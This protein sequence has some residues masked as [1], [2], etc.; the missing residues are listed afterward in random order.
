[1][2][3][4]LTFSRF[5]SPTEHQH[6][7]VTGAVSCCRELGL[8]IGVFN[9]EMMLTPRGPRLIEVNARMGGFYLHNW[10]R[11]IYGVDLVHLALMC[12]CGVRPV[13]TGGSSL[14]EEVEDV[15][16][17]RLMGIMLYPSR[18]R[19]ALQTTATPERLQRLHD[20]G[21]V[22]FTQFES[23]VDCS[24][25]SSNEEPYCNLAVKAADVKEARAK[26]TGVCT[27]LGL[28]TEDSLREIIQD[29]VQLE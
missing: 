21:H 8:L 11:L 3:N 2:C 7:L 1:M 23:E 17:E 6:R 12:A 28:E 16:K 13:L 15:N 29:F 20:D 26:L 18:H 25:S 14:D 27:S 19:H 24:Q 22:I 4:V 10:I 9:V 5:L